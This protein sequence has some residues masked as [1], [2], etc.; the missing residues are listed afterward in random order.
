MDDM[1]A[2]VDTMEESNPDMESKWLTFWLDGQ[3]YGASVAHV[4]QIVS[5]MPITEIPEYPHYSKGIINI[6]GSI[7]PL[8]DLRI[9]LGKEEAEY[10]DYTC[11]V[12][13]RIDDAMIGFIADAVDAVVSIE[14]EQITEA[15]KIVEEDT[16]N[17]LVGIARL[18]S[19]DGSEEKMVLCLDTKRVLLSMDAD[20]SA[21]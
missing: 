8:I 2:R 11:I 19:N 16:S 12:I 3:L 15:P 14:P 17:Y 20:V 21:E 10:N 18:V 13:C 6:R 5:M 1:N 9:R 7:V 4:E